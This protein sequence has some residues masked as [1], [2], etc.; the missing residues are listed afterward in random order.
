MSAPE[1]PKT[2]SRHQEI[3][4]RLKKLAHVV[5]H[6]GKWA[7]IPRHD[8]QMLRDDLYFLA[9]EN[10]DLRFTIQEFTEQGKT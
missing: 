5:I 6:A 3:G 10:R 1:L 8:A 2:G 9:N 4:E 7:M